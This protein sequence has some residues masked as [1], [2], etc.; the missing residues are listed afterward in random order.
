M[1]RFR[2]GKGIRESRYWEVE[3]KLQCRLCEGERE[4]W[5]HAWEKCREWREGQGTWQKAMGW[6]LGE[7][8]EGE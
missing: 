2:L 5:G 4:T 7:E 3:Q 8:G 6:M 1:I